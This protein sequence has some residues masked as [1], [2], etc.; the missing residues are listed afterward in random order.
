MQDQCRLST[1]LSN[2]DSRGRQQAG[3]LF[4]SYWQIGNEYWVAKMAV[5]DE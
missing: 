5:D 4:V 2:D 3:T 1:T